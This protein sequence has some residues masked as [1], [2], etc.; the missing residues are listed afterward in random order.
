LLRQTI[1][2]TVASQAEVEEELLYLL[3]VVAGP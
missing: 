2:E 3:R 1:A